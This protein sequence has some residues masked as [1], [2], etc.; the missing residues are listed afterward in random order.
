M[1]HW[2]NLIIASTGVSSRRFIVPWQIIEGEIGTMLPNDYK[3]VVQHFGPGVFDDLVR[4][5]PPGIAAA[6]WELRHAAR[7][8]LDLLREPPAPVPYPI[9]PEAGGVFP[10]GSSVDGDCFYWVTEGRPDEWTVAVE[11]GP[12]LEWRHLDMGVSEFIYSYLT[13]RLPV[14]NL[15]GIETGSSITFV[16]D[17]GEWHGRGTRLEAISYFEEG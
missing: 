3:N 9:F 8:I 2:T 11:D 1:D 13:G 6:G 14:T 12:G 17:A 4:L 5:H 15:P 16:A 7:Q 10:W